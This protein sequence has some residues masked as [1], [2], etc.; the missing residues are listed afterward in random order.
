MMTTTV[1]KRVTKL[2]NI[3]FLCFVCCSCSVVS[4]TETTSSPFDPFEKYNRKIH[5]FNKGVDTS[6]LRPASE[7]YGNAIPQYMRLRAASFYDNLQEPKRFIN[8][9]GQQKFQKATTDLS[10]FAINSTIGLLGL[11]DAAS[12]IG[13]F[14]EETG[15]DETFSYLNIPIGPYVEVPLIGPS[16]LRGSFGLLADYTFNPLIM[17]SGPLQ[18]LS[19]LTFEITNI[20]NERYEYAKIIESLLY[21]SSDSYSSSRLSY[22]QKIRREPKL[23]LKDQFE[24]FDPS[25]DF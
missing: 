16:S 10:R 9:S 2:L 6:I 15:F 1:L 12:Q 5:Q 18:S 13:L 11:F 20:V 19:F 17:L 4:K 8:H 21:D 23:E 22:F 25:D 3:I 7:I 14:P 24:L